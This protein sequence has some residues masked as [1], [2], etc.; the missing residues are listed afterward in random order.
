[1]TA[2]QHLDLSWPIGPGMPL[3]PGDPPVE[4]APMGALDTHG[5]LSHRIA[6][7]AHSGTHV[8]A[9]AHVIKGGAALAELPLERFMG[10][11]VLLDLRQRPGL[12]V[13]EA[14]VSPH[15]SWL[16]ARAPA[17]VLIATGD[18]AR[19]GDPAYYTAGAH[20]TP[21]AA[22]L[23]AGLPGLSGVGL[24]AASADPLQAADLPAHKALLGAGT[25]IIENLRGLALLPKSGFRLLCLPV[26]PGDGSPV[27]AVAELLP[28][29][30][31]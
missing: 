24:D 13:T 16:R 12:A 18:E 1:M 22:A 15:V 5:F 7:P 6:L 11:A 4:F 20:L 3:F 31:T 8:D 14:D 2:A 27:R 28:E 21:E 25:L 29:E 10:P 30:R 19:Y 17:F 26:L 9:P 23:L